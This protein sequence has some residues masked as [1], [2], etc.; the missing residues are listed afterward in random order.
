[1]LLK[2]METLGIRVKAQSESALALAR[3]LE[4]HPRI[5]RVHYSGLQSHPQHALASRQQSGHG[6]VLG[7]ELRD[8]SREAA[9]RVVDA[10]RIFSITANLGDTRSTVTH[11]ATTTHGRIGPEARAR[12]GIRDGLLRLSIGLEAVEDLRKDLE[13]AMA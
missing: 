2:G 7:F 4:A 9:W 11:P 12:A 6:T 8:G 10:L 5:A 3:W 1:V 13:H